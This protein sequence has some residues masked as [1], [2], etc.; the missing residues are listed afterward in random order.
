MASRSVPAASAA[1]SDA[2]PLSLRSDLPIDRLRHNDPARQAARRA[3]ARRGVQIHVGAYLAGAGLMVAIWLAGAVST[4]SWYL[5][6]IWPILGWGIGVV[7]H[8]VPVQSVTCRGPVR[9]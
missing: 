1:L 8:V 2:D 9:S 3:A 5:W 6:P 7:S 4:G